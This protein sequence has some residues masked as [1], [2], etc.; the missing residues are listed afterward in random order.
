M[1]GSGD[2]IYPKVLKSNDLWRLMA[3]RVR[4][5]PLIRNEG[6]GGSNP[7]CGTTTCAMAVGRSF[8]GPVSAPWVHSVRCATLRLRV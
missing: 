6:V 4:S 8:S 2:I 5:R 7:S 1:A 3:F